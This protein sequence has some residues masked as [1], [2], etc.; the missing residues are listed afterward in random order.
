MSV[1]RYEHLDGSL[2]HCELKVKSDKG[3]LCL[4]L[5]EEPDGIWYLDLQ[6]VTRT[7]YGLPE[8]LESAPDSWVIFTEG[9]KD[10]QTAQRLGLVAVTSGSS[11]SLG[12]A[13]RDGALELLRGRKIALFADRDK[14]GETME[15]KAREILPEIV[16][17]LR[18]VQLPNA[19]E[20]KGYDLSDFVTDVGEDNAYGL[21]MELIGDTEPETAKEKQKTERKH[22]TPVTISFHD[23]SLAE[24]EEPR[25]IVDRLLSE[26]LALW[27]GHRRVVSPGR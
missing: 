20:I 21:I 2:N 15:E 18:I 6:N 17:E 25:M 12:A 27:C 16:R 8:L 22:T 3:K 10:A 4:P 14:A 1:Y 19:E 26:G 24:I 7:L 23:L 13:N 9:A 5:H 11:G